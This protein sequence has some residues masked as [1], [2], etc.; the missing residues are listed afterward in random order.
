MVFKKGHIGYTWWK[1]KHHSEETKQKMSLSHI[2][3]ETWNK[4]LTNIYSEETKIKMGNG[5]RGKTS[6]R[7]GKSHTQETKKK[8]SIIHSREKHYNFGKHL[9]EETKIKIGLANKGHIMSEEQK[10]KLKKVRAKLVLPMKD[11]TIEVK[12]QNFLKELNMNFLTHQYIKDI[13]HGY[14]CDILIPS[15]NLVIECDGDYWHKYPIGNDLDHIRTKELLDKGFKV[16]RLWESEIRKMSI[17][18]FEYKIFNF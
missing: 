17:N 9:S 5:W 18:E 14:Q 15:M 3:R 1:G 12:I 2:G 4:G 6:N 16:L 11:T 7:S 10:N 8:L 13:E